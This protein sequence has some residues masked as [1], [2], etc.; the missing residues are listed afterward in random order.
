MLHSAVAMEPAVLAGLGWVKVESRSLGFLSP[1]QPSPAR[2][3]G[4][5]KPAAAELAT[6]HQAAAAGV[7]RAEPTLNC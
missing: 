7:T 6:R 1:A 5:L 3:R 4:S 2:L